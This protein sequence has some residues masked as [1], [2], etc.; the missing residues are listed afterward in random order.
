M[1]PEVNPNVYPTRYHVSASFGGEVSEIEFSDSLK[2]LNLSGKLP[3][4]QEMDETNCYCGFDPTKENNYVGAVNYGYIQFDPNNVRNVNIVSRQYTTRINYRLVIK[5]NSSYGMEPLTNRKI[6]YSNNVEP[7]TTLENTTYSLVCAPSQT[8]TFNP[9]EIYSEVSRQYPITKIDYDKLVIFPWFQTY[10]LSFT[11]DSDGDIVGITEDARPS[12][13]YNDIK[14]ED[15]TAAGQHYDQDLWE[16]GYKDTF[17]IVDGVRRLTKRTIVTNVD[18]V[19]YYGK[20]SRAVVGYADFSQGWNADGNKVIP[21]DGQYTWYGIAPMVEI[22]DEITGSIFYEDIPGLVFPRHDAYGWTNYSEDFGF[23]A[24]FQQFY[25]SYPMN[26]MMNYPANATV[27]AVL[28]N[29]DENDLENSY[30]FITSHSTNFAQ[31]FTNQAK[32]RIYYLGDNGGIFTYVNDISYDSYHFGILIPR[33]FPIKDLM[34]SI[35][36]LGL[37][38]AGDQVTAMNTDITT[39]FPNTMYHGNIDENGITDGTWVQGEDIEDIPK[40]KD[41]EYDPIKPGPPTPPPGPTPQETEPKYP[42]H[43]TLGTATR[44]VP[45]AG[46]NFYAL[47]SS[48]VASFI[49]RLWSQPKNFYEAIQIAGNQVDSIFD[50]IQSFRYYPLNYDFSTSNTYPVIF[51]TGAVLKESDGNTNFQLSQAFPIQ[52]AITAGIWNLSDPIYHWRNNFLDYSP[53]LKM[54][55]YLPFAG[56]IELSPEAV[57]S[58]T[59]I[60]AAAILLLVSFDIE[61]GTITY[62]VANQSSVILAQKT[63]K[64]AIDLPLSGNN[65]AEQSAAI[66]RAQFSTVKQL[67]GTGAS[68]VSGAAMGAATA[69]PVGAGIGLASTA[70]STLGSLGDMYLQNSLAHKAVPVE[71]QGMGGAFSAL[72]GGQYPYITINRQKVSNPPNYAHTTG[73]LVEGTYRISSLSGLTVCR[74]VDVSGITQ[75]TDKEKAQI[76]QIL[77]SGFYA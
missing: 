70:A 25:L 14:P 75:A 31:D 60:S 2:D 37:F 69:G 19:P 41:I 8:F 42:G 63:A 56:T 1:T 76:K 32:T 27:E 68:A 30:T 9:N 15:K 24:G 57:A 67:L 54:S 3:F 61:T 45:T 58:H 23:R 52:H 47:N 71:I 28:L 13:Q 33:A 72:A 17:E 35:A 55:I 21:Q 40:H 77:E 48:L 16:R 53:Y 50:Y 65:A 20:S 26:T 74:N 18:C 44:Y 62:Y 38:I 49:Q 34:A 5:A 36:S 46:V 73:Y 6:R 7:I 43:P 66:L 29:N 22:V 10:E 39:S 64:I 51:G 12:Y 59:D 4:D 11:Y